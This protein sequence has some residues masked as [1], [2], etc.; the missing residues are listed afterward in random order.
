M[1]QMDGGDRLRVTLLDCMET[2]RTSLPGLTLEDIL[3]AD[4]NGASP[5]PLPSRNQSNRTLLDVMHREHRH[6]Y[7][8][9]DKTAWKSFREKLRLKRNATVW[10]SSNP[11]PSLNSPVLNRDS[12]SHQLG[13]LLS[14][15]RNEGEQSQ[16]ESA[17]SGGATAE[18]R[19]QLGAVLAEER[20]LSARE[21]ETPPVVTTDMQP[22]R[23]SLMELLDENE[24]QMS[25]VGGG[26]GD[27]EEEERGAVEETKAAEISCCVCMVRS[28]GA[29]FIPCGHTFCRLCSRELW[30]QRGNCPL[31]NTSISEILDLF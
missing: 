10:I 2:G 16:P 31:C 19:L 13:S 17:S 5:Q 14:N 26:G 30:V 27:G 3:M 24:G 11:I 4:R 12:D 18:G 20:A 9:R 22:A 29:A 23:M 7:N 25:L 15:S 6:D 21:E 28:K 1:M 8:H